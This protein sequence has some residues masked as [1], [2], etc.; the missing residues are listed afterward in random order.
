M[1]VC[2]CNAVTDKAIR[3]AVRQH[4]PHTVKQLRELVPIGT[5]CGKC[6]RQARQIMVEERGTI[7]PMH[8]VA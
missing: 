8:E 4:N 1:Y 2:L 6:I 5:D 3:N 7:I